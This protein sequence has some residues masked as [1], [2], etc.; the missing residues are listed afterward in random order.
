MITEKEFTNFI[1]QMSDSYE[2]IKDFV[3]ESDLGF[4]DQDR[5]LSEVRNFRDIACSGLRASFTTRNPQD[6]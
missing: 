1:N 4:K 2:K 5:I 6:N 3:H